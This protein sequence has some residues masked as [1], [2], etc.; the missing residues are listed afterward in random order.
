[1]VDRSAQT[2]DAAWFESLYERSAPAVLAYARRRLALRE[3]AEDV[4]VEVFTVAWRRREDIPGDPEE[5]LPWLYATAANAIAHTQR[6]YARR[7]RLHVKIAANGG[8]LTDPDPHGSIAERLDHR[9]ALAAAW[10]SLPVGDQEVLRLWAWEGLDGPGLALALGCS[11]DAA[12]ARLSRAKTR[13]RTELTAALGTPD[14]K[15]HD[16]DSR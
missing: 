9:A 2:R 10:S 12:R 3:D 1:M 7:Q 6:S 16:D 4:L 8:A 15:G 13:L 11:P 14:A 5:I